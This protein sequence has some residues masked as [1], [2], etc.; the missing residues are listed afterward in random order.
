MN[1]REEPRGLYPFGV[2][3]GLAD[4]GPNQGSNGWFLMR[5]KSKANSFI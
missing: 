4:C 3:R 5:Q 2:L 1:F